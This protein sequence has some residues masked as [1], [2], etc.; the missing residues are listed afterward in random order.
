MGLNGI[1]GSMRNKALAVRLAKKL[2]ESA[3]KRGRRIS[4][5]AEDIVEV[6]NIIADKADFET[7]EAEFIDAIDSAIEVLE[8]TLSDVFNNPDVDEVISASGLNE[9]DIYQEV[10]NILLERMGSEVERL[11]PQ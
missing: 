6:A 3:K 10:Y 7:F 4:E 2:M 5:Q 11:I 1:G 9:D 8:N